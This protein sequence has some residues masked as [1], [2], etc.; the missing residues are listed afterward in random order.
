MRLVSAST[1]M[2]RRIHCLR[3]PVCSL[4]PVLF[5]FSPGARAAAE[6][7]LY[8]R[9]QEVRLGEV[10]AR[11]RIDVDS[12]DHVYGFQLSLL[13]DASRLALR[14]VD[15]AGT[16]AEGAAWS[17]GTALAGG[18]RITWGVVLDLTEP[19][20]LAIPPGDGQHLAGVLVDVTA[21]G[22]PGGGVAGEEA[23]TPVRFEDFPGNPPAKNVLAGA[24][25]EPLPLTTGDG[26]VTIAAA[27]FLR[28]D[29]NGDGRLNLSDGAFVLNRLFRGGREPRCQD[30]ADV[31]DNGV[32]DISDAVYAL[33]FLFS[34]G[35]PP[36]PPFPRAGEDPTADTL[37]CLQPRG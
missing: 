11:I 25:G 21:R 14:E 37:G 4:F 6:N 12:A 32:I 5:W 18:A 35:P 9:P 3:V 13:T 29:A 10:G 15:L 30:A 24:G 26:L 8:I 33:N 23:A 22:V 7:R 20:A 2:A 36:P 19:L 27:S 31:D 28:G 16:V 34:R 1:G 17:D